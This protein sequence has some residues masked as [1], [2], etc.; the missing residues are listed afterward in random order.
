MCVRAVCSGPRTNNV[1]TQLQRTELQLPPLDWCLAAVRPAA[2]AAGAKR[3]FRL[4]WFTSYYKIHF[5]SILFKNGLQI[6]RT[7]WLCI[8]EI[9]W[10]WRGR[11][12][13]HRSGD[14]NGCGS[15][16]VCV[17]YRNNERMNNHATDY[18]YYP[19]DIV[20]CH[21]T[22]SVRFEID[23]IQSK[24]CG[25]DRIFVTRNKSIVV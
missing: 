21:T 3:R 22:Q 20:V 18:Y 17:L 7:G 10:I 15:V 1:R 4:W 24:F 5:I 8:S 14:N 23:G 25:F 9:N 2:A 16:C 13:S 19:M 6:E 11:K 12:L